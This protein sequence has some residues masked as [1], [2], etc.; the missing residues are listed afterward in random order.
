MGL[1]LT[2]EMT[3]HSFLGGA[4]GRLHEWFVVTRGS[5]IDAP[6]G[7]ASGSAQK[8]EKKSNRVVSIS[9]RRIQELRRFPLKSSGSLSSLPPDPC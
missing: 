6:R 2:I 9:A 5:V 1:N 4:R 7:K 8:E 3:G